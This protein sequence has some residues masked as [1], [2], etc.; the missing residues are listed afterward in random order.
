[1]DT[2]RRVK[3]LTLFA[4]ALG[5]ALA[6]LDSTVVVVALPQMEEDLGP[7]PQ[8]PAVGLP[9]LRALALGLL[10]RRRRDRRPRRPPSHVHRRRHPLRARIS[11]HR[12]RAERGGADRRPCPAGRGWR[13]AHD[14][15]PRA[16]PGHLGGR[17]R[18]GNRPLD[19]A[20]EPRDGGR[21]TA[22]RRHRADRLVAVGVP[23]QRPA[24][25]R[26]R[27][28]RAGRARQR[29]EESRPLDSRSRRLGTRRGRPRR[30]HVRARRGSRAGARGGAAVSRRRG[31]RARR[32][33]RV[34]AEGPRPGRAAVAPAGARARERERRHARPLRRPRRAVPVP[35]GLPAVPRLLADRRRARLRS[36][37][38]RVDPLGA[39]VGPVRGSQRPTVAD[40]RWCADDRGGRSPAAPRNGSCRTPGRGAS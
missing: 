32:P 6:F 11:P 15:E 19:V 21:A 5:S 1:M 14:D 31:R 2:T 34:D 36:T 4:T 30:P 26:H 37:E 7:R 8:R 24:R 27:R 23:D 17:G 20:H 38:H 16:A 18:P 9:L 10:P 35:T 40:R 33:R 3:M 28:A 22:R 29:R 25:G 39:Q 12:A 13:G